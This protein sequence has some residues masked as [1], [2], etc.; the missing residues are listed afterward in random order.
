MAW[1]TRNGQ[2]YYYEK[3]RVNGRVK[4]VYVGSGEEA[5]R[6]DEQTQ[7][8]QAQR[9]AERKQARDVKRTIVEIEQSIDALVSDVSLIVEACLSLDGFHT[10]KGQI[11]KRK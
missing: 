3:R 4:S 2:R 1:E 5:K 9:R 8:R 11:R 10:Q 7:S 6:A